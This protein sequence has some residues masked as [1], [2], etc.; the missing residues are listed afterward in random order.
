MA[1]DPLEKIWDG[2]LSQDPHQIQSIFTSLDTQSQR[3]V[4]HHLQ[5]MLDEKGWF[6]VQKQSAQIAL[7]ALQNVTMANDHS[8]E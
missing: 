7:N 2:L 8:Q 5:R 1:N 4:L 3:S 6:P